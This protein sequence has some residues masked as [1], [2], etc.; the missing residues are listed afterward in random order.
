VEFEQQVLGMLGS[1][2]GPG[3]RFVQ[4][5]EVFDTVGVRFLFSASL[6]SL[7][8]Q[9]SAGLRCE[10]K[11]PLLR[12]MMKQALCRVGRAETLLLDPLELAAL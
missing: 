3:C 8:R 7:Q 11:P 10:P 1:R 4:D 6:F 12:E 9:V 2:S 5:G